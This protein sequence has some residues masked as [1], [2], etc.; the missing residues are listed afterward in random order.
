MRRLRIAF[1]LVFAVA[2]LSIMTV[3]FV[4]LPSVVECDLGPE[5][6][7]VR[8]TAHQGRF[9]GYFDRLH[10]GPC[11]LLFHHSRAVRGD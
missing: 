4:P 2:Y 1:L 11:A 7:A 5:N 3:A 10:I 9:Q 8:S 6:I